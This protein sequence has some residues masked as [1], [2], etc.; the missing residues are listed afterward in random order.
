[1]IPTF[2]L[3]PTGSVLLV[4]SPLRQI[5]ALANRAAVQE[6]SLRISSLTPLGS[7]DG[8][9]G[10]WGEIDEND[11]LFPPRRSGPIQPAFLGIIPTRRCNGACHY[12]D[13]GA[14]KARP[15]RMDLR[16][17]TTAV[18]WMADTVVCGRAG[19]SGR[20]LLRWRASY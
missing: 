5:S 20:P 14:G 10:L 3:S 11:R 1:M 8:V 6:L 18:D 4:Y 7:G 17:V 16:T 9:E 13:F 2:T 19:H 15:D 12:C